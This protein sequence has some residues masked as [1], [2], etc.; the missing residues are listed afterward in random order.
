MCNVLTASATMGTVST[1][2]VNLSMHVR[3]YLLFLDGGNGVDLPRQYARAEQLNLLS[4]LY[5]RIKLLYLPP[6]DKVRG[7]MQRQRQEVR[8]AAKIK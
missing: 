1:H 6:H 3:R 7:E 4:I 8:E 5:E 2:L